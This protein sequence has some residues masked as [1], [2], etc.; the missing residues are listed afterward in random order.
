MLTSRRARLVLMAA[1]A[2]GA[3]VSAIEVGAEASPRPAA[4]PPM[5]SASSSPGD[6]ARA[7]ARY[8]ATTTAP[9]GSGIEASTVGAHSTANRDGT[10]WPPNVATVAYLETDRDATAPLLDETSTPDDRSV[11]VIVM[12]GHFAVLTTGPPLLGSVDALHVVTGTTELVVA[13]SNTATI[14]DFKLSDALPLPSMPFLQAY[15]R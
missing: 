1:V 6:L 14:L 4:R 7:V 2:G 9:A 3:A 5:V 12:T 13:D 10:P 15:H 11:V 8:E